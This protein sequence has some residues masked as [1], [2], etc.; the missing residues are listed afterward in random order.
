ME[1]SVPDLLGIPIINRV[2]CRK[3]ISTD[4]RMC[5]NIHDTI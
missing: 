5:S 1:A 2:R 3:S 4:V